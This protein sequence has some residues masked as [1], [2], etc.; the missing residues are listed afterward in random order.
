M[1]SNEAINFRCNKITQ[2]C[3]GNG[4]KGRIE[5]RV[6]KVKACSLIIA[7]SIF[8]VGSFQIETISFWTCLKLGS[9]LMV[10]PVAACMFDQVLKK[11]TTK[12]NEE[13]KK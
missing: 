6:V 10:E 13:I 12:L 8:R 3:K 1:L 2:R 9:D 7:P 11:T 5:K 4:E